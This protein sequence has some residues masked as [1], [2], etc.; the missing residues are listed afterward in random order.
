MKYLLILFTSV[1]FSQNMKKDTL[2]V[3]LNKV[4]IENLGEKS[5]NGKKIIIRKQIYFDSLIL[6]L[7]K[8]CKSLKRKAH[9]GN[10]IEFNHFIDMDLTNFIN[11]M[12][13]FAIFIIYDKKKYYEIKDFIYYDRTQE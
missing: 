6:N 2:F 7:K 9:K 5:F 8:S 4:N 12:E 3:S 11:Q 10:I 13:K 1:L